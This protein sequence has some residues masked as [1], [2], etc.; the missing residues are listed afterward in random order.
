MWINGDGRHFTGAPFGG[1]KASGV[2]SEESLDELLSYTQK[3]NV[4]V[5]L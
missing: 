2:G 1:F 3:K 4:S 5:F